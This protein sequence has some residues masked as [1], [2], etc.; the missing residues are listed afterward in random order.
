MKGAKYV[1]VLDYSMGFLMIP[2]DEASSDLCTF[3]TP[4]G[5]YK[6]PRY[7]II[8]LFD[9]LDSVDNFTDDIIIWGDSIT[10]HNARLLKVYDI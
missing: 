8:K 9:N 6:Y 1:T 5:R 2:L 4:F 10:K 3:L 7:K